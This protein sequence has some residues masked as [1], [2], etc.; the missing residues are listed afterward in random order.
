[1]AEQYLVNGTVSVHAN[2]ERQ[3][4]SVEAL[5]RDLPSVE[6][7]HGQRPPVGKARTDAEGKFKIAYELA[8]FSIGE[9]MSPF[10]GVLEAKPDLSFRVFDAAGQQLKIRSVEAMNSSYGPDEIIFNAPAALEVTIIIEAPAAAGTSEYERLVAQIA[11]VLEG[12]PVA[13]L[14][15]DDIAF[16]GNELGLEQQRD[17]RSRLGWLRRSGWLAR[18]TDLPTEAFYGWGRKDLPAPFSEL[19]QVPIRDLP[20]VLDKLAGQSDDEL[21]GALIAAVAESVIPPGL[22]G[23]LD[24]VTRRLRRRNL[25]LIPVR[26]QLQD[27]ETGAPLAEYGVKTIDKD[28]G[29]DDRGFDITAVDGTFAFDFYLPRSLPVAPRQFSFRVTTPAGEAMLDEPLVAIRPIRQD[30][31]VVIVKIKIPKAPVSSVDDHLTA[32]A[33]TAPAAV[34]TWLKSK[35]IATLA[36]IRRTGGLARLP[37]APAPDLGLLRTLDALADL[38]RISASISTSK[39]LIDKGYDSVLAIADASLSEFTSLVRSGPTSATD[40]DATQLHV[41]ATTQTALL[42]NILMGIA[43]DRA[44]GRDVLLQPQDS[45]GDHS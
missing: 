31:E 33:M 10:Q 28:G 20:T 17:A 44:N 43:A 29:D 40:A 7:R 32:L 15:D 41:N 14:T 21:R 36:D 18:E 8:E 25:A 23:R 22:R 34:V 27:S 35:K 24:E 39:A 26:A 6:A 3:G 12:I 1:M 19:S 5:E 11:P 9:G 42:N 30:R 2:T 38:D 13:E 4:M 37:D 16:L 45:D